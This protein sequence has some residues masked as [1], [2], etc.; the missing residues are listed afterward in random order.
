MK[1]LFLIEISK[2]LN[3][4]YLDDDE[5]LDQTYFA[6]G[7][8]ILQNKG[9]KF[10]PR[11]FS[12]KADEYLNHLSRLSDKK[13]HVKAAKFNQESGVSYRSAK[14]NIEKT[15]DLVEHEIGKGNGLFAVERATEGAVF[16]DEISEMPSLPSSDFRKRD[17]DLPSTVASSRE[18]RRRRGPKCYFLTEKQV[19]KEVEEAPKSWR[20]V[21]NDFTSDGPKSITPVNKTGL[22]SPQTLPNEMLLANI[23]EIKVDIIS[24]AA[25]RANERWQP[26]DINAASDWDNR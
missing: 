6:L 23:P 7:R 11:I 4:N 26:L 1:C 19:D 2:V 16:C 24:E 13:H 22:T 9:R 5:L 20:P 25:D 18:V 17:E 14:I 21:S 8:T 12:T 15:Q 3:L 10:P